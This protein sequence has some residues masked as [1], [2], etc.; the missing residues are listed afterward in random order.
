MEQSWGNFLCRR[1]VQIPNELNGPL[2]TPA[3]PDRR[4][5]LSHLG[6]VKQMFELSKWAG[7]SGVVWPIKGMTDDLLYKVRA[8]AGAGVKVKRVAY[9]A[10]EC[11]SSWSGSADRF[12][13]RAPL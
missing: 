2:N 1:T 10:P 8:I 5:H 7:E 11:V 6:K 3:G 9:P 12:A 13:R 4:H